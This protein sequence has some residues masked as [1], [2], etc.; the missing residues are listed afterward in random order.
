[1]TIKQDS[2]IR[3]E[4]TATGAPENG[5][6]GSVD[7]NGNLACGTVLWRLES[8]FEGLSVGAGER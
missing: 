5:W 3:T 4:I 2:R 8:E 6:S 1:M 7:L